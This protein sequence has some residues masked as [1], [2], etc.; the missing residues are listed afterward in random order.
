MNES[1]S[2]L[3]DWGLGHVGIEPSS[4]ILDVGCG[5]GRTIQKMAAAATQG[6]V[7]GVDYSIGSV[8]MSRATNADAVAAGRVEVRQASVSK[9]PFE[10]ATFDLVTAVE[11]HYYWPDLAG[12][13]REI[14]RVTRPGGVFIAIVEVYGG[15][16]HGVANRVAMTPLGA[17]FMS[18]DEH[19]AWLT[20]AGYVD[21]RVDEEKTNGWLCVTGRRPAPPL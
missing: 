10:D 17:R 8:E 21:V 13:L 12:D 14:H 2:A 16:H 4:T 5:G 15:G 11:T 3:T 9:L 20:A 19:R 7:V 18:A 1:H 6:R